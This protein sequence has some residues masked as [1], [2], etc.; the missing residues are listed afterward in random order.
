MRDV[1]LA[2]KQFFMGV[3]LLG[4]SFAVAQWILWPQFLQFKTTF[5]KAVPQAQLSNL[6]V[7]YRPHDLST[8]Q[9]QVLDQITDE[10]LA[11]KTVLV[12]VQAN[13]TAPISVPGS[14]KPLQAV[15][16]TIRVKGSYSAI[17]RFIERFHQHFPVYR[18][19]GIQ[20]KN[21]DS[22]ILL[23]EQSPILQ[24]DIRGQLAVWNLE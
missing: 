19:D 10:T 9:K 12:S 20:I 4:A 2:R 3:L 24:A 14:S 13:G 5:G 22:A 16:M 15:P 17:Q 8:W 23:P 18:M 7:H 6:V 21:V 1:G 11:T